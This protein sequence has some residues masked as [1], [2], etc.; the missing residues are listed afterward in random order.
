[1]VDPTKNSSETEMMLRTEVSLMLTMNSLVID[2]HAEWC[3]EV[4]KHGVR[5]R[6]CGS[7]RMPGIL[8]CKSCKMFFLGKATIAK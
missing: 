5:R 7:A 2:C 4:S 3:G 6:D 8:F 1:M